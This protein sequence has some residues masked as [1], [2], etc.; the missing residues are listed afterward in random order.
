[1]FCSK[2]GKQIQPTYRVCPYCGT[3]VAGGAN[4]VQPGYPYQQPVQPGLQQAGY[5]T[6][7]VT[8]N[9][10]VVGKV[11]ALIGAALAFIGLFVTAVTVSVFFDTGSYFNFNTDM[12]EDTMG[13]KAPA[14][15]LSHL[16]GI[17]CAILIILALIF[18]LT[19]AKSGSVVFSVLTMIVVIAVSI[20]LVIYLMA[21]TRNETYIRSII[22]Y[23]FGFYGPLFGSIGMLVGS[24]LMRPKR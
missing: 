24:C 9:R 3:P 11:I 2:C 17:I 14:E 10:H 5:G 22:Q 6:T 1:M 20:Y 7:V 18:I 13:H 12:I 15:F 16:A 21:E 4:N 8:V 19:N 23:R